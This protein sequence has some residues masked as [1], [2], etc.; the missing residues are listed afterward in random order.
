VAALGHEL[1]ILPPGQRGGVEP[2]AL[3]AE[4]GHRGMSSILIE[5]GGAVLASFAEADLIDKALVFV[6]PL[7]IGGESAPSPVRGAGVPLLRQAGRWRMDGVEQLG[8]DVLVTAY[9]IRKGEGQP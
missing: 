3:L 7:I 6:A 1:L 5:G 8:A 4:L 2:E 9:P